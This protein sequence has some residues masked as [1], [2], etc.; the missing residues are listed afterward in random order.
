[1]KKLLLIAS[2][3]IGSNLTLAQNT[4]I[5][6][7]AEEKNKPEEYIAYYE[8]GKVSLKS[9]K[10]KEG[11]TNGATIAYYENGN[12]QSEGMFVNDQLQGE[13]KFY[14]ENGRR[15]AEGMFENGKKQGEWKFYLESGGHVNKTKTYLNGVLHGPYREYYENLSYK[16][17]G[18]Y[19]NDKKEGV[20]KYYYENDQ[21]RYIYYKDDNLYKIEHFYANSNNLMFEGDISNGIGQMVTYT[22]AGK[23]ESEGKAD[24]V[25]NIKLGDWKYYDE[26]GNLTKTKTYKDGEVVSEKKYKNGSDD[27]WE[28]IY[29]D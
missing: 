24:Q 28:G 20:W 18:Q 4:A 11:R 25:K 7:A 21:K 22:K 23:K 6:E 16:E 26:N 17:T 1:M 27:F 14:W 5:V 2:L 9:F 3:L 10:D 19:T 12:K 13:W 29:F 15:Q 8:S